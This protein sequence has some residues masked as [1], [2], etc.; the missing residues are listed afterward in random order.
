LIEIFVLLDSIDKD[1]Y[2]SEESASK[3]SAQVKDIESGD[4]PDNSQDRAMNLGEGRLKE[5]LR[6]IFF[7]GYFLP[8]LCSKLYIPF[9]LFLST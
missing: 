1:A 2:L 3:V 9:H 8:E 6:V 7:K 5:M 4:W